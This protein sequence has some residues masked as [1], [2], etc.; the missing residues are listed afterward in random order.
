MR[1]LPWYKEAFVRKF[2]DKRRVPEANWFELI[3]SLDDESDYFRIGSGRDAR[4]YT[5]TH[6]AQLYAFA[7][8]LT[9]RYGN[10]EGQLEVKITR[11]G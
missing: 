4:L 6:D 5:A 3:G 8:D 11:K 1:A 10:N 7:N 9:T 2:E